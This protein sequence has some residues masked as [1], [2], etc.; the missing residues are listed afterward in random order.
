MTTKSS[1][2]SVTNALLFLIPLWLRTGDSTA[3][4]SRRSGM[5]KS[6]VII[7]HWHQWLVFLGIMN[8]VQRFQVFL[9]M[10]ASLFILFTV[11]PTTAECPLVPAEELFPCFC[12]HDTRDIYCRGTEDRLITDLVLERLTSVVKNNSRDL[13]FGKLTIS[14]SDITAISDKTF[15]K[16]SF[17]EVVIRFNFKLRYIHPEAFKGSRDT[18]KNMSFG[19]IGS[20]YETQGMTP[21]DLSFM[22]DMN[23]LSNV[24]LSLLNIGHLE[25]SIFKPY[26]Q[27][28]EDNKVKFYFMG[29]L[30]D[31][32]CKI[33]WIMTSLSE[34][35]RKRS[36]VS[37]SSA[38]T[39]DY[40]STLACKSTRIPGLLIPLRALSFADF[41]DCLWPSCL[42]WSESLNS[43]P[44]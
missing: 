28:S 12:F 37:P 33:K 4:A 25:E 35:E 19:E 24:F 13:N 18:L 26:L 21:F 41:K 7:H 9:T 40:S 3:E 43:F 10:T 32:G 16:M 38:S 44:C 31:C 1:W 8:C 6:S 5:I 34:E 15:E 29:L 42:P 23:K 39:R 17:E 14:Q 36:L 22:K 30:F 20:L 27:R 2:L 11:D